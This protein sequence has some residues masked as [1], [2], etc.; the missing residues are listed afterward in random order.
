[1]RVV[2]KVQTRD[3]KLW[4]NSKE[5]LRWAEKIYGEALSRIAGKLAMQRYTEV[6][7]II[8][9]N[10]AVFLELDALKKDCALEPSEEEPA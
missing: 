5:A 8:E 2:N 10:L 3:G 6:H 1:M 9:D 7:Q 4:D